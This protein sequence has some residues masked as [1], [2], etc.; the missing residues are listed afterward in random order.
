MKRENRPIKYV[1][2]KHTSYT[3]IVTSVPNNH[4][5][6]HSAKSTNAERSRYSTTLSLKTQIHKKRK[7]QYLTVCKTDGQLMYTLAFVYTLKK[8]YK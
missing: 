2:Y 7:H 5:N 3:H 1:L 6:K 8:Y 4:D